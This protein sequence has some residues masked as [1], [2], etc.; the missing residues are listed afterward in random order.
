MIS[1]VTDVP[2]NQ[3]KRVARDTVPS[4]E[5]NERKNWVAGGQKLFSF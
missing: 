3:V 5:K 1:D 4:V 2:Y